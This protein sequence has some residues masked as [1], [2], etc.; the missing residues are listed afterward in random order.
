[1]SR[2]EM[3][4]AYNSQEMRIQRVLLANFD[5]RTFNFPEQS[6]IKI[7]I[8]LFPELFILEFDEDIM[9]QCIKQMRP[10]LLGADEIYV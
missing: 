9:S 10:K 3:G 1:M 8:I 6:D 2:L 7:P 5:Q 4:N